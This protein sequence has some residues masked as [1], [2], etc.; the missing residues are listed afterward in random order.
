ML[1]F[2]LDSR[3]DYG[4]DWTVESFIALAGFASA[5]LLS[6]VPVLAQAGDVVPGLGV[7]MPTT[8]IGTLIAICMLSVGFFIKSSWD[9]RKDRKELVADFK[10]SLKEVTAES[11]AQRVAFTQA[12]GVIGNQHDQDRKAWLESI[13]T[14]KDGMEEMG[15]EIRRMGEKL[16]RT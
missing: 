5:L 14:L 12:I 11:T 9:E 16:P 10:G 3:R 7:P 6:Q 13:G 4:K 8:V 2:P 15:S 1:H